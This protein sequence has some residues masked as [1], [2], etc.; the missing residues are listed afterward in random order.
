MQS[1]A[2]ARKPAHRMG[3][4]PEVSEGLALD[5]V[6][7]LVVGQLLAALAF[8]VLRLGFGVI[9]HW[10]PVFSLQKIF[11]LQAQSRRQAWTHRRT[12]KPAHGDRS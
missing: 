1:Y 2:V 10:A 6:E 9:F 11:R 7:Q 3:G 8:L 12:R 4:V 5:E